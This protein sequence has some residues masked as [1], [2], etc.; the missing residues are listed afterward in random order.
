MAHRKPLRKPDGTPEL[1]SIDDMLRA[2]VTDEI[3]ETLPGKGKPLNLDA[4]FASG[5]AYRMA[6]KI[7]KDNQVL[8]Q[9]LQDRKD[10]ETHRQTAEQMLAAET[11]A[12]ARAHDKIGDAARS[13]MAGFPDKQAFQDCFGFANWPFAFP[14]AGT[15]PSDRDLQPMAERVSELLRRYASRR[16]GMIRRYLACMQKANACIQNCRKYDRFSSRLQSSNTPPTPIDLPGL[17][18]DIRRQIPDLPTFP[19]DTM[20]RLKADLKARRPSPWKRIA[21]FF[22]QTHRS[23]DSRA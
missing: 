12:L 11:E 5:K 19:D 8:P 21:R 2:A 13:L 4:Y 14:A 10:A 15:R 6:N 7:L 20:H 22:H 18:A 1:R 16:N 9:H 17:E 23:G 3:Y